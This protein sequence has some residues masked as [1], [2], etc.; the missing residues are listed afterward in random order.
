MLGALVK[1][2]YAEKIGVKPEDFFVVSVMPCTAKK[3]EITREEMFL[4]EFLM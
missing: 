4:M 1:S 3:F 2:F